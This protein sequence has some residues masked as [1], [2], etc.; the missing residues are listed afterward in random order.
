MFKPVERTHCFNNLFVFS[1]NDLKSTK[2]PSRVS[3]ANSG[4]RRP[5]RPIPPMMEATDC[6][7][8][9]LQFRYILFG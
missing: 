6:G 8:I 4:F 5:R 1:Q 9:V 2:C 3:A 7:G